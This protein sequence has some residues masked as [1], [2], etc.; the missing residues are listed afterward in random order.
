MSNYYWHPM[1]PENHVEAYPRTR[2]GHGIGKI[3]FWRNDKGGLPIH[4]M[5]TGKIVR[6]NTFTDGN[7]CMIQECNDSMLGLTFYIRYL[8]GIWVNT[9]STGDIV[10][11]GTIIGYTS[12]NGGMYNDHLHLDFSWSPDIFDPVYGYLKDNNT[13]IEIANRTYNISG[14]DMHR[15]L[16]YQL[17]DRGAS[18]P[19]VPMGYCWLV[20]AQEP[21]YISKHDEPTG[22]YIEID[23]AIYN[24]G[25]GTNDNQQ[26]VNAYYTQT[27]SDSYCGS[28]PDSWTTF[29]SD[30]CKDLR[31]IVDFAMH[32]VG[33]WPIA[34]A[35]VVKLMRADVLASGYL[36][37][38]SSAGSATRM[39]DWMYRVTNELPG[40][41]GPWAGWLDG[42]YIYNNGQGCITPSS[43][44]YLPETDENL[45]RVQAMYRNFKYPNIYGTTLQDSYLSKSNYLPSVIK[46]ANIMPMANG[47]YWSM[48][49]DAVPGAIVNYNPNTNRDDGKVNLGNNYW[50][51][52]LLYRQYNNINYF[53]SNPL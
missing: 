21:I 3:D 40:F 49:A 27:F 15:A 24:N 20:F 25:K 51:R 9:I 35:V 18:G 31:C 50:G 33:S 53:N 17:T 29:K 26:A 48:V 37:T 22:D 2:S 14:I 5:C 11:K 39:Y 10:T 36:N 28:Y 1:A 41:I 52:W 44:Q 47:G 38:G 6:I 7:Y 12:T 30:A 8:H 43:N 16:N 46:A 23:K 4:A 34:S 13:K 42:Y 32:E 45:K 19:T